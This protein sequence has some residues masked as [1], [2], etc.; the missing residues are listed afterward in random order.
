[1]RILILP[2]IASLVSFEASAQA[3]FKRPHNQLLDQA[4]IHLANE[5]YA[6]AAKIYKRLLPVDTSF[7]EVYYEYGVCLANLPGQ[8]DNAVPHLE[9]AARGGHTEAH[10]EL[11]L[12]RHRQQRFDEEMDL[13]IRYK[14]LKF[15]AVKDL[16][17]ERRMAMAVTAKELV[18]KPVDL[19]IRNMGAMINSPAHDYCPLVTADGRTMYFTSRREGTTG[20]LKDPSGQWLEDIY[21]AKKIDDH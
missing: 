19:K 4:K 7:V 18:R 15:R 11:A 8:K 10:Y 3:N 5:D 14:Q 2:L 16:E 9:R 20:R 12:A 17:V 13:L 1:M 21:M 6:D